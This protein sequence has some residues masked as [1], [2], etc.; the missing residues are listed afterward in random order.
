LNPAY[1]PLL[2]AGHSGFNL[3]AIA[4]VAIVVAAAWGGLALARGGDR[5]IVTG[6]VWAAIAFLPASNLLLPTG[7][8]LAERTLYLPSVGVTLVLSVLLAALAARVRPTASRARGRIGVLAG[9]AALIAVVTAANTT[10]E[11]SRAWHDHDAWFR[12]V[13]RANPDDFHSYLEFAV[14]ERMVGQRQEALVHLERA[15][16]LA[17]RDSLVLAEFA[18]QLLEQR[19]A[20]RAVAVAAQLMSW[21]ERR[22][23][24]TD[25]VLYLESVGA[26][27]GTDSV[28]SAAERLHAGAPAPSTALYI[29]LAHEARGERPE[30]LRA[31]RDGLALSSRD[32]LGAAR[33]RERLE[34]LSR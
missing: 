18:R 13:V 4:F 11:R 10:R 29:G 9:A 14:Y 2:L 24:P 6:F 1:G 27:Y 31:Y 8:I 3:R 30:A 28:L 17:P 12:Q 26:A 16:Q 20:V 34:A 32:S 5:R 25:V 22:R 33:I 21:P 7:Q 15:Y 23:D 19:D